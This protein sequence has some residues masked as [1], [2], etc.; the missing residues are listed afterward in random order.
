[1][2]LFLVVIVS[3]RPAIVHSVHKDKA[4]AESWSRC[5]NWT[6]DNDTIVVNLCKEQA[7]VIEGM[8]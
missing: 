5:L 7:A 3:K 6:A 8:R 2:D 1:M 4:E